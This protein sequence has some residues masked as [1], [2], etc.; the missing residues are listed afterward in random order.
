M[1]QPGEPS[2]EVILDSIKRV[3]ARENRNLAD[4]RGGATIS[5]SRGYTSRD[6]ASPEPVDA[7]EAAEVLQLD[8][9]EIVA[10]AP[11]A[12]EGED[13]AAIP[14]ARTQDEDDLIDY[15]WAEPEGLGEVEVSSAEGSDEAGSGEMTPDEEPLSSAET[16]SATREALAGLSALSALARE[17]EGG[18]SQRSLEELTRELLRPMLAEWLDANL[19][20][21][22][23][24][25]VQAEIRRIVG[26]QR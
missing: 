21:M 11:F 5:R 24:R 13:A 17:G 4:G 10:H 19:P 12:P 7:E 3:I 2:V 14:L 22:V 6:A 23:E 18:M 26:I 9:D 16:S 1:H 8:E 25:L 15:R 20:P